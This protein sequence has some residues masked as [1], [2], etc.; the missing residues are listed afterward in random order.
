MA[1]EMMN[2]RGNDMFD[3]MN[4][5]F[6]FPKHFFDENELSNI[7]QSDVA[8]NDKDYV[9]KVD[10]PGMNKDK[11]N[12]NYNNGILSISGNRETFKDMSDKKHNIIHQ[13]RSEGHISRSFRLP[14]VVASDIHA[15]YDNGVL[16]VTLPKQTAGDNGSSIHID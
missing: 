9:V 3:A 13:E 8:E 12:L 7:M 16:T 1:N 4:D 11:I 14:N 2:R 10:M 5:W 6:G 15:K